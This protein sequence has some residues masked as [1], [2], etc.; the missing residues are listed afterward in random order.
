MNAFWWFE[1]KKLAGMARPGFN[2]SRWFDLPYDEAVLLG[3]LGL[4]SSGT[5]NLDDFNCH[6][7]NYGIKIAKFYQ[8]NETTTQTFIQKLNKKSDLLEVLRRLSDRTKILEKFELVDTAI[9]F[10]FNQTRLQEEIS[11]LKAQNIERIVSLTEDHHDKEFLQEHFKM[12]HLPIRDLNSPTKE[13]VLQMAEILKMTQNQPGATAVHC[14]AGIGRT[15]TML[16]ASHLALGHHIDHLKERITRR[17]PAY[18]LTGNQSA[19][20]ETC[21]KEFNLQ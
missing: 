10:E 20:I 11:F 12:H 15:S 16:L 14:L 21:V 1:D 4:H 8:L 3:W 9:Q 7:Q 19:F 17:N 13:Q 18:I 5:G 6:L 2:R